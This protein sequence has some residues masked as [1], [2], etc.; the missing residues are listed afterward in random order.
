MNIF[1]DLNLVLMGLNL[2]L[3][4]IDRRIPAHS[5]GYD[6]K[7]LFLRLVIT[8]TYSGVLTIQGGGEGKI[9]KFQ[10]SNLLLFYCSNDFDNVL[11]IIKYSQN[12]EFIG[13]SKGMVRGGFFL[14][15]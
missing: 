4:I 15:N 11:C 10:G 9:S 2:N 13:L 5:R 3:P 1:R 6:T 7:M 14:V 8:E 12:Q